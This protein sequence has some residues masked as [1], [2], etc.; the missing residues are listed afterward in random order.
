[1]VSHHSGHDELVKVK[2]E[3]VT[4]IIKGPEHHPKLLYRE[5]T[6]TKTNITIKSCEKMCLSVLGEEYVEPISPLFFEQQNYEILIQY[7]KELNLE[8][9]HENPNIRSKVTTLDFGGDDSK[10]FLA[11]NINFA[12]NIGLS[13][14]VIKVDGKNYFTLTVEVFPIKLDY[15][16]DYLAIVDDITF[17]LYSLVFDFLRETYTQYTFER[18]SSNSLVEFFAI[19]KQIYKDYSKAM[20]LILYR[21]HHVLQKN[22]EVVPIHKAKRM[23]NRTL[24]WIGKHPNSASMIDGRPI[25]SQALVVK[26]DNSYDTKENQL[27]KFILM[28]TVKRLEEFRSKYLRMDRVKHNG[29]DDTVMNDIDSMIS[30]INR[31]LNHSFMKDVSRFNGQN[32][33]SL[34]FTMAPGYRDLYKYYLMLQYGLSL[35]KDIFHMSVK[36]IADLYEYWCFVKLNSILKK[37]NTLVSYEK[38]KTNHNGLFTTLVKDKSKSKIVYKNGKG[39]KITIS[40]NPSGKYPTGPQKPDNVLSL[41]KIGSKTKYEYVFDA[42]YRMNPAQEGTYYKTVYKTP[43]PEEDAINTMHRYRDAIVSR[44]TA[45]D[46]RERLMFGAYV[47]FPLSGTDDAIAQYKEHT[48]YKSI[49]EVNIGGLP[50]LPSSTELVE[51]FLEKLIEEPADDAYER[52]LLPKG[53]NEIREIIKAYK[54]LSQKEKTELAIMVN[55]GEFEYTIDVESEHGE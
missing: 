26:K 9:W 32:S 2:N 48:F 12:N 44:Q 52:A 27:A 13:D 39:E 53:S 19:I 54:Q 3:K 30:D 45:L 23:D 34:V 14:L 16:K 7:D 46:P 41:E 22:Y 38:I 31:R 24:N 15:H 29:P 42:K 1:M 20:D 5:N 50:F 11:G 17:E 35:S 4:L 6:G 10:A 47:L 36:D 28:S 55:N 37:N 49:A 21:P 8:F 33:M 40:Y 51:E 18:Q 25:V 43:G